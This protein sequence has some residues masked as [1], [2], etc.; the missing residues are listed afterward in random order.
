MKFN[1]TFSDAISRGDPVIE[2]QQKEWRQKKSKH[3]IT[4]MNDALSKLCLVR[5]CSGLYNF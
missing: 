5:M 2:A 1:F 3:Q 4:N